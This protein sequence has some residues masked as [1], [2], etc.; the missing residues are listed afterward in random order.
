MAAASLGGRRRS[1]AICGVGW[2]ACGC[3]SIDSNLIGIG[4]L[5]R[6]TAT[7]RSRRQGRGGD[8]DGDGARARDGKRDESGAGG[9]TG[10]GM[11]HQSR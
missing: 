4:V 8:G 5:S 7:P 10:A 11:S 3:I 1:G 2:L 6:D 9:E